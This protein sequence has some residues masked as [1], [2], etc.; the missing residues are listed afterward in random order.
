MIT[1]LAEV[2]SLPD[3]S[4]LANAH[5]TSTYHDRLGLFRRDQAWRNHPISQKQ[6]E[7][8]R[9]FRIPHPE[10]LNSG[11][12]SQLINYATLL[13]LNERQAQATRLEAPATPGQLKYLRWLRI[14]PEK[15]LTKREAGRLIRD[16]KRR[17]DQRRV[18]ARQ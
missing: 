8:L 15:G 17:R 4:A 13:R 18:A 12:A 16:S 5:M 1:K 2:A 3:A 14:V 7:I 11:Q 10:R 9:R 6:I